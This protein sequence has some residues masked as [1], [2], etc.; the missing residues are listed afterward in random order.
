M[1]AH[2]RVELAYGFLLHRRLYRE[3][4]VLA[5][6]FTLNHGRIGGVARGARRARSAFRQSLQ[7]FRPLLFSWQGRNELMTLTAAEPA[8]PV[9]GLFG[10]HAI[11]GFYANEILLRL[12]PRN[13]PHFSLFTAYETLLT[14]LRSQCDMELSLRRFEKQ[15]LDALGYG[16]VLTHDS[17]ERPIVPESRYLYVIET[18]PVPLKEG[19]GTTDKTISGATLLGLSSGHLNGEALQEAKRLMRRVLTYYIGDKPLVSRE[20]FHRTSRQEN[21]D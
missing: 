9:K 8:H 19:D 3:T 14:A 10:A 5:E 13:D 17:Q 4:S 1:T 18:G 6:I 11:S 7:A 12:L 15:L 20:L 21:G 16:L 2:T